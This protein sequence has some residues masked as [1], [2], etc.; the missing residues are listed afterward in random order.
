M[1]PYETLRTDKK[2]WKLGIIYYCKDD[3]R[4][5]VR[6]LFP[7][8]WTWNFAHPYVYW[9]ILGSAVLFTA[10]VTLAYTLG[11]RDAALYVLIILLS[12]GLIMLI[13]HRLSIP[14]DD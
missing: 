12:L 14:P 5:I 3:P 2:N 9:V 10:P 6:Q 4:V 11:V 13:A 1:N 7:M 8:G